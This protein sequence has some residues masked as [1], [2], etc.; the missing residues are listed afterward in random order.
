MENFSSG[1][2]VL[3]QIMIL[4]VLVLPMLMV[5]ENS[6]DGYHDSDKG[7]HRYE[8]KLLRQVLHNLYVNSKWQ[9]SPTMSIICEFVIQ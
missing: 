7:L 1:F 3:N 2:L 4:L 6:E 9:S 5:N 8:E